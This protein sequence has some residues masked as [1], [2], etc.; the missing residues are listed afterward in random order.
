MSGSSV[1]KVVKLV[2]LPPTR[3]SPIWPV[4]GPPC[5]ITNVPPGDSSVSAESVDEL[6]RHQTRGRVS[7]DRVRLEEI[8]PPGDQEGRI[9][10]E[11]RRARRR[12]GFGVAVDAVDDDAGPLND[13]QAQVDLELV[14]LARLVERRSTREACN[15]RPR[16][17]SG[18]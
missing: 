8:E 4:A 9:V 13:R 10:L 16:R 5:E 3:T 2:A 12:I 15:R 6:G 11:G 14:A 1:T 7:V 17:Q 18:A